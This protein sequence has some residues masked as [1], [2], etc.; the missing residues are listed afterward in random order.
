MRLATWRQ[1][2][3]LE[4]GSCIFSLPGKEGTIR[5][6]SRVLPLAIDVGQKRDPTAVAVLEVQERA[7][8]SGRVRDHYVARH[9]ERLLLGAPY[10]AVARRIAA[11]RAKTSEAR[12]R[13]QELQDFELK[14]DQD[15]NEK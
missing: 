9:L 1:E 8:A 13:A 11:I 10:P 5:G 2:L 6:F 4:N 7:D 12:V 3:E 15:A 14:G